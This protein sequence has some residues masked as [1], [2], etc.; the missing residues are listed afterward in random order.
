MESMVRMM[1]EKAATGYCFFKMKRNPILSGNDAKSIIS[2]L[3][4]NP[5]M[6]VEM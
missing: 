6:R 1:D 2:L 3:L 5:V 4:L